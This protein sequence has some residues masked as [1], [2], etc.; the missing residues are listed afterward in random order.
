MDV[1]FFWISKIFWMLFSPD[2]LLVFLLILGLF[3]LWIKAYKKAVFLLT[4]LIVSIVAMTI[5]PVGAWLLYPLEKKFLPKKNLPESIDGIIVLGGAENIF[6]SIYWDQVELNKAAERYFAFIHLIKKYPL[7]RPVFTGGTGSM[8]HQEYKGA[9]VARRLFKEQGLDISNIIFESQ[10]KNTFENAVFT[11]KLINP[12]PDEKWIL[13]TTAS[14]MPR[15]VGVFSKVGW[16]VIPYSVDH[17]IY[18][19]NLF[20]MTLNFSR[21]LNQFKA[22]TKEW[23]GLTAY[24]ITGK[25]SHLFPKPSTP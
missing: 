24:Y 25:T 22:A 4:V 19:D 11:Y 2:I 18:P 13:I 3:L 14:H 6:N 5:L 16:D 15:S 17:N 21:N 10:S 12:K 1:S 23:L 9:H 20:K 7:A 8:S